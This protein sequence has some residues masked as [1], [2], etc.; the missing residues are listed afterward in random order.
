MSRA[1]ESLP[2]RGYHLGRLTTRSGAVLSYNLTKVVIANQEFL[3]LEQPIHI[4]ERL[5]GVSSFL[6][7]KLS[8]RFET[9]EQNHLEPYN[10]QFF[11]EQLCEFVPAPFSFRFL[12]AY[13]VMWLESVNS[14]RTFRHLFNL[15]ANGQRTWGGGRSARA[16]KSQ[17]YDYK[18]KKLGRFFKLDRTL[19]LAEMVNLLWLQQWPHEWE[20][21]RRYQKQLP[22]YVQKKK[23]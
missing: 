23:K 2:S 22:W 18:L 8:Q 13:N 1:L 3:L 10:I 21:S 12:Y 19:F 16:N 9:Y 15:P 4:I 7:K 5:Y 11:F 17:L 14:Y 20:V 6:T